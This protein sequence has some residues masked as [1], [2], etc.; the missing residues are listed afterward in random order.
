VEA[1][2]L[3]TVTGTAAAVLSTAVAVQVALVAAVGPALVHTRL[4]LTSAPGAEV[5][6]KPL[7][8]GLMSARVSPTATVATAVSHAAGVVAGLAQIWYGTL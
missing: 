2:Q 7:K 5:L 8:A 1:V 3:P 6:G 4:P